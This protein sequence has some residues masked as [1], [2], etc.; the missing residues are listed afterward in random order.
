MYMHMYMYNFMCT[1][2]DRFY[3]FS[4]NTLY[5]YTYTKS[6]H[7]YNKLQYYM[8]IFYTHNIHTVIHFIAS[9]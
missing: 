9:Q 7:T 8:Y 4:I 5:Q 1:A 2:V 3:S 6:T